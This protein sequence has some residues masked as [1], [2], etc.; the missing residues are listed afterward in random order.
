MT[1]KPRL[2]RGTL[3]SQCL[4]GKSLWSTQWN[5]TWRPSL[6]SRPCCKV[7]MMLVIVSSA[8]KVSFKLW[9]R[10]QGVTTYYTR[11]GY[12]CWIWNCCAC[13]H[14]INCTK[15]ICPLP[16]NKR[17]TEMEQ[18]VSSG[19]NYLSLSMPA[20]FWNHYDN[21][22]ICIETLYNIWGFAW[23]K[24]VSS[25]FTVTPCVIL[26]IAKLRYRFWKEPNRTTRDSRD[27][28]VEIRVVRLGSFQNLYLSFAIVE[29]THGVTANRD[30]IETLMWN[31]N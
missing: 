17:T 5:P 19:R 18:L 23:W 28:T 14:F 15:R 26:T 7:R 4:T 2:K 25:R 24:S 20:L 16:S 8:G 30:D 11:Y 22:S 27:T 10:W 6:V 9:L 29:I 1:K 21:Q 3:L 31:F 12:A 13:Q